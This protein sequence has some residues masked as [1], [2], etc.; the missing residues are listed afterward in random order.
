M[1]CCRLQLVAGIVEHALD[2]FIFYVSDKMDNILLQG[3][4]P[5]TVELATHTGALLETRVLMS[6]YMK[7][8]SSLLLT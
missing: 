4:D 5:M 2:I 3:G 7:S 6:S 8:P 1:L